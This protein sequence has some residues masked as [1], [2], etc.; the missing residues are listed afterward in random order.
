MSELDIDF[1]EKVKLRE[2][3]SYGWSSAIKDMQALIDEVR[4]LR[5]QLSQPSERSDEGRPA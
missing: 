2:Y 3:A 1:L 4:R 5:Q